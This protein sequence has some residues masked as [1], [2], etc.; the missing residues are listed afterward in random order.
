MAIRLNDLE[1]E[2]LA[3]AQGRA[4]QFGM[5]QIVKVGDFF[6]AADCVESREIGNVSAR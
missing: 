5:E 1:Q 4:R 6:D 2:M 3:G